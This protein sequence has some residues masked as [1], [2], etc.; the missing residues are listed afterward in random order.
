MMEFPVSSF[1]S[2]K[3]RVHQITAVLSLFLSC[4]CL[5]DLNQSGVDL[6]LF[7]VDCALK[8]AVKGVGAERR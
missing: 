5:L 4:C 2:V 8:V 1:V 7:D 6:L 3:L